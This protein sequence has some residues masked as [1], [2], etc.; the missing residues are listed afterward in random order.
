M[1]RESVSLM[2]CVLQTYDSDT[3]DDARGVLEWET[4]MIAEINLLKK[5]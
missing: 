1:Q 5:N 2:A 4:T 3:Y